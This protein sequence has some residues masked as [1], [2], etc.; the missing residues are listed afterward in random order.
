VRAYLSPSRPRRRRRAAGAPE[1]VL[2][3]DTETTIDAT[4]ALLFGSYRL[5]RANGRLSQEGL[6]HADNLPNEQF[7][8]L[9]AYCEAH[10]AD[11]DGRLRLLSRSQF[12]G[13][14]LWAMG[15]EVRALIVG[16]NL[17][18]DL[19]R[20][21]I[22]SRPSR[23]GGFSLQLFESIDASGRRWKHQFRPE[24]TIKAL[25]SK[26]Q[27][28]SFTTPARLDPENTVDGKAYRG[29]FLDLH[30]LAYALSD[31]SFTLDGAAAAWGVTE[32]KLAFDRHGEITLQAID[33]NR[34]DTRMTFALYEAL[35]ADWAAHPVD[36]DPEQGFSPAALAKAYFR[37][38]GIT[39]P[40]ERRRR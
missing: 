39:P 26:R 22:G 38:A 14:H 30:T 16:F 25:D 35:V 21:A 12:A 18:F 19:S 20:L 29:R 10:A 13:L 2:T 32:R 11:N 8:I 5:H 28:I 17:P 36:L 4:Q 27:L 3:L 24:I 6:I 33:Y 23:N 15:Y 7:A 31:R 37:A 40:L 9:K 1:W 34:Q